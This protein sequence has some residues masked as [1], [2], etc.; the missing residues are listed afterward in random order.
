MIK[1]DVER[2]HHH[3]REANKALRRIE[4]QYNEVF[5]KQKD[6]WLKTKTEA[7][8]YAGVSR[9]TFYKKY[10]HQGLR[11]IDG[12]GCKKSWIDDF[13]VD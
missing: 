13:N 12:K 11:W 10:I 8:E 9:A 3:M 7:S 6:R 1:S 5:N 2:F 4:K